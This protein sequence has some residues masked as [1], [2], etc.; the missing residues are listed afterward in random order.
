MCGLQMCRSV[1]EISS[2]QHN[3]QTHGIL[4]YAPSRM[5][6]SSGKLKFP[7]PLPGLEIPKELQIIHHVPDPKTYQGHVDCV[8]PNQ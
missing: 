2:V 4:H 5:R 8:I 7:R 6:K 3:M 1:H